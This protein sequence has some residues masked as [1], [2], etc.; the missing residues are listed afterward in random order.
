[1]AISTK[2]LG[3]QTRKSNTSVTAQKTS[4]SATIVKGKVDSSIVKSD[5]TNKLVSSNSLPAHH[6]LRRKQPRY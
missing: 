5:P 1:M 4:S 2:K 3:S 6:I